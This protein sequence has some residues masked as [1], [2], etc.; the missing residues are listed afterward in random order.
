[1][2][3]TQKNQA[4]SFLALL[5]EAH[6]EIRQAINRKEYDLVLELLGQCQDG[7][8][9]LGEMIESAEGEGFPT[10]SL[11]EGYCEQVYSIYEEICQ[12]AASD[13][14]GLLEGLYKELEKIENSVRVD[15]RIRREAVFLPYKVSMWDSLES[16]WQAANDDPDC[17][18]YVI[19]IPY[20]DRG[21]DGS[22][23]EM[24]YEGDRYPK[25]V[26]VLKYDE[27]DFGAH[28]PDMIFIHN[29]Y[30]NANY[31]TS[32]HP[33]FYSKNLKKYT[34]CLVY[35]PYYA[36]TGGM[37][38]AQSLCPAY[39]YADYIVIQSEKYKKFFD[40][41][42][43]EEKF[44]PFGSP[45]FDS[46]IRKCQNPPEPPESWKK[47]MEGRRA[48]FYNTSIN[49]MLENTEKFLK[50]MEY[51]FRCFR[52]R[53]DVC[54]LWRPHPLMES[55]FESMRR[56]YLPAY[57]E[58]KE[59]FI[60]EGF[61]IFDD[62]P[63][64]ENTIAL[65]D[66]YIGD[67]A[68]SV[69]S[70]FG[71]VGKPLFIL[72]N[73]IHH[74]PEEEDWRG[75]IIKGFCMNGQDEWMV[76]QGNKLYHAPDCDYRYEYYCDL[77]EYAGGNYYLR[78]WEIDHKVYVC[79][80]NAQEILVAQDRKITK[81]I[82]LERYL[83]NPGAFY[84]AWQVGRYLFL[85]PNQYPA[86]V[87]LDT[88]NDE[89][90]YITG[91]NE[92]FSKNV[93]GQ[94]RVGGSN[95][96]GQYLMIAS[97]DNNQVVAIDSDSMQIQY[98][99]TE[100][101]NH[102][103]C[104]TMAVIGNGIWLLPYSGTTVTKWNPNTG[105]VKEYTKIPDQ[106]RCYDRMSGVVC[107]KMPFSAAILCGDE[108][109]LSPCLGNMFLLLDQKSGEF[110]EWKLPFD[111]FHKEKNE[112]FLSAVAGKFVRETNSLGSQTYQYFD[113]WNR[114]IY[115]INVQTK[116]YRESII[117]FEKRELEIHTAGFDR[118]SDWL[119]YCCREDAFHSLVDF[120]EQCIMGKPFSREIQIHAYQEIAAN[121]DGTCGEKIYQFVCSKS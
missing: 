101:E 62:T 2:R 7:A 45:K 27:F 110:K 53:E 1:M 80:A 23:K 56:E 34:D 75:E 9:K 35:V 95:V 29:P 16:I 44:L 6:E 70:L 38:E 25:E 58:L 37:S 54:L 115:D 103:G 32:V 79:P 93:D 72:N 8:I 5:K 99:T 20:Y 42:I 85:I 14:C 51:V 83:E 68:T 22:L 60:Q 104:V 96:Y 91:V 4:E 97:P 48:Y 121:N 84:D 73:Y 39:L 67:A 100:A 109:L 19:P 66:G 69:T 74:E 26:P 112:Y 13:V 81:R 55:T 88:D 36:T 21:K 105:E 78:A 90:S 71:V 47:K 52:G 106:F 28:H 118:E 57:K 120:L 3:R 31:V 111:A 63:D 12:G 119:L 76:T 10:I 24:H 18:A 49:G 108:V 17:D 50:K 98:L 92:V 64:I 77:C 11:L 59:K 102:C 114:R 117:E 61:G 65:C 107:E 87:R 33:F 30:D 46:V 86:I 15:I 43:P 94:W 82:E 40:P 89:V 41:I 113:G 116:E